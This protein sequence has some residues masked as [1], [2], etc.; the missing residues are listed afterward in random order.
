[1]SYQENIL[2]AVDMVVSQRL[3]EMSF[4]KTI[5][6][7]V[8]DDTNASKGEYTVS[9]QAMTMVVYAANPEEEYKK[10][11]QVYVTVPQG[12][13]NLRKI[14]IG[15][16]SSSEIP[17]YLY[18]NPMKYLVRLSDNLM[19]D[20]FLG[21]TLETIVLR[22]YSEE[23]NMPPIKYLCFA[24]DFFTSGEIDYTKKY[25]IKIT[26]EGTLKEDKTKEKIEWIFDSTQFQGNPYAFNGLFRQEQL[27]DIERFS[28]LNN[29]T[30][31]LFKE[32]G[33]FSITVSNIELIY[34]YAE[35]DLTKE[36]IYDK[37]ILYE[38]NK[39]KTYPQYGTNWQL[40]FATQIYEDQQI[41]QP[42]E[43]YYKWFIYDQQ[44]SDVGN[45][46]FWARILKNYNGDSISSTTQQ[47]DFVETAQQTLILNLDT[48]LDLQFADDNHFVKIIFPTRENEENTKKAVQIMV[49]AWK[50][51]KVMEYDEDTDTYIK[52]LK[53][54]QDYDLDKKPYQVACEDYANVTD[55]INQEEFVYDNLPKNYQTE[56]MK[57]A[58]THRE[59]L[60]IALNIY[61]KILC[62][63]DAEEKFATSN[64]LVIR[65][66]DQEDIEGALAGSGIELTATDGGSYY[67]YDADS[68]KM[69]KDLKP[70]EA[71]MKITAKLTGAAKWIEGSTIVWKIPINSS[72]IVSPIKTV[73]DSKANT[74]Y[75][76]WNEDYL[77]E[78]DQ[79]ETKTIG[80]I[81][82]KLVPET[83][84]D[85]AEDN[86]QIITRAIVDNTIPY[87]AYRI[88]EFYNANTNANHMIKCEVLPPENYPEEDKEEWEVHD[89]ILLNFGVKGSQGTEYTFF[90]T[91]DD[92]YLTLPLASS[93]TSDII[94][95]ATAH[96]LDPSGNEVDFNNE[97]INFYW[98]WD[99]EYAFSTEE[100][101]PLLVLKDEEGSSKER[102]EISEVASKDLK[103]NGTFNSTAEY[104]IYNN[105][106]SYSKV[107]AGTVYEASTT[108]Y[109]LYS[110][111]IVGKT[112]YLCYDLKAQITPADYH[113]YVLSAT[114]YN[115]QLSNEQ[116]ITYK[117][118]L[119]IPIWY[120]VDNRMSNFSL[121][122]PTNVVYNFQGS[123]PKYLENIPYELTGTE[124]TDDMLVNVA[125]NSVSLINSSNG[126]GLTE[127]NKLLVPTLAPSD[128]PKLTLKIETNYGIYYHPISIIRNQYTSALLNSWN[129]NM[130]IDED[131]NTIL[132]KMI[133]A[134]Q[135]NDRNQF[136]GVFMGAVGQETEDGITGLYGYQNGELRF[137]F[138][139]KGEAYI[140][141]GSDNCIAFNTLQGGDA[142]GA[143]LNRLTIRTKYFTLDTEKVYLSNIPEWIDDV[144]YLFRLGSKNNI[145]LSF[146]NK[147]NLFIANSLTVSGDAIV[148]GTIQAQ[149]DSSKFWN[150]V[151]GEFKIGDNFHI[152]TS[153]NVKIKGEI[154]ATSGNIA[155]WKIISKINNSIP[156][157][158]LEN[159]TYTEGTT[160]QVFI[161]A[162]PSAEWNFIGIKSASG[163]YQDKEPA[164]WTN[165][166]TVSASG[167]LVANSAEINGTLQAGSII[168]NG[169]QIGGST[170]PIYFNSN[171][172]N[173]FG[174]QS[175]T[176]NGGV[177]KGLPLAYIQLS[178]QTNNTI[179]HIFIGTYSSGG[180]DYAEISMTSG[181]GEL[182]GTW[183]LNGAAI[184]TGSDRNIKNSIE[185]L[186]T[187][188]S[189]LVYYLNPVRYKYN[190]GTSDRYHTGFITQEVE[191]ALSICN[192]DTQDFAALVGFDRGTENET[193]GL[194][195][196]E[197]IALNTAAIQA[198]KK[199]ID[200]LRQQLA[201]IK[202]KLQ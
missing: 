9:Y 79:Y 148:G 130:S 111:S 11:Q 7:K 170:S 117:A 93:A 4:D 106:N 169:T 164:S 94:T 51:S 29:L 46:R 161:Q 66:Q 145:Q 101:Q 70:A 2:Q 198:Q 188:Y 176:Q 87:Q 21:E 124:G 194:R 185:N 184:S 59:R 110:N 98:S 85:L 157:G 160:Y 128:F 16:V 159:R 84:K 65:R 26:G 6:C 25:G 180:R 62:S 60:S 22:D 55:K 37:I 167:H 133:G 143:D 154:T 63:V 175:K 71:N 83:N 178:E 163:D 82:Y 149:D 113:R 144:G 104:Y 57:E 95:K 38:T 173:S 45:G 162:P 187:Q 17:T 44:A 119:P 69:I 42:S 92:P 126:F 24:A 114:L 88:S 138:T 123:I 68:S 129:G 15:Y 67:I 23:G 127:D 33:N 179:G 125:M 182:H 189:D 103:E 131:N 43:Y 77:Q 54:P 193:W 41:K 132:T 116:N 150:L 40:N 153:G 80:D 197:F 31:E 147:G 90:I 199:E 158:Y 146:D 192:I 200:E 120:W 99:S 96:F 47:I 75:T 48:E 172:A 35:E 1:M 58:E 105:D 196:S 121:S 152:D 3:N 195:Y 72:M 13:F 81:T 14:I 78:E 30:I 202:E 168:A 186:P 73:I 100:Q 112:C 183:K 135:K 134:G 8:E 177:S 166:F 181:L 97:Q 52:L 156:Y 27:F 108:Y 32:D 86:Y 136:S 102:Y 61:N 201:E 64:N 191:N 109:K 76:V 115:W 165:I 174:L 5:V 171:G 155:G 20:K 89:A 141:T 140:G 28:E 74:T 49:Q 53:N 91:L 107:E 50:R 19:K 142:A 151:N 139:E 190:D 36:N 34:G 56:D 122:G 18:T 10:G 39:N 137:K 118:F 12:D